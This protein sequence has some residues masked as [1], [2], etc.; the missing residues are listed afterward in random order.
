MLNGA[1]EMYIYPDDCC[2][3]ISNQAE[4]YSWIKDLDPYHATVGAVNCNMGFMFKDYPSEDRPTV[5][6]NEVWMGPGQPHLQLSLD[7][8]MHE[9]CTYPGKCL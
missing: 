7:I 6:R 8:V 5:D 1:L 3:G 2:N 9:N 4:I